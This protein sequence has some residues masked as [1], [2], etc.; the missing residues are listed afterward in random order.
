MNEKEPERTVEMM[1]K[2]TSIHHYL[3]QYIGK[4]QMLLGLVVLVLVPE[5]HNFSMLDGHS[6]AQAYRPRTGTDN[7]LVRGI[8]RAHNA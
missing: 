4:L 2:Y 3:A 1:L 8:L 7:S 6:L 5:I